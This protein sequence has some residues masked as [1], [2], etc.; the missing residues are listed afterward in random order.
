VACRQW[1]GGPAGS[2]IAAATY[3]AYG[4]MALR[5]AMGLIMVFGVVGG[6][7]TALV[8]KELSRSAGCACWRYVR[9][10]LAQ[11][12][13]TGGTSVTAQDLARFAEA[14]E[15]LGDPDVMSRAWQ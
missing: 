15:D 13:A 8:L 14:F 3:K 2:G 12:A 1:P 4:P 5:M 9:R 10:R 7:L 11:D 6:S